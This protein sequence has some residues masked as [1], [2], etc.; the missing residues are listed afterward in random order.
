MPDNDQLPVVWRTKLRSTRPD[1]PV[2]HSEQVAHCLRSGLIGIG[3]GLDDLPDRTPTDVVLDAIEQKAEEGWGGRA[4]RIVR[5]FAI[6]AEIGDF[7]WTRDT[8][9]RYLL[10][11]LTGPHRY[12]MT[13]AASAVDVH[14]VRDADWARTP[15]NDL[16]VPGGVIRCFI[17]VGESF[18]RIHDLGA[19]RLTFYLWEKLHGRP[20][21]KLGVTPEEILTSYLDPY[22]VEDL[23]YVWLQ[24]AR[25]YLALP[26]AR[27]RDMPAYEYTMIHRENGRRAIAQVKTGS[28]PV[29]LSAL[30]AAVVDRETDTYA[31]ATSG[32]YHGDSSLV[33]EV[34]ATA[35]LLSFV[36]EHE[37][38]L[39]PRVRTWFQL[40][41]E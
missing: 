10:C 21:P 41:T 19:R 18:S 27:Q 14:Q 25:G 9:G 12:D 6:E 16:D 3:W 39:P 33:T 26:R 24:I 30:A 29:D 35:E 36:Q 17:G 7:V 11:R 5:R 8:R 37:P 23:I 32:S 34:I 1:P 15:L 22:D 2:D 20:L 31:Y 40:A 4:A 28:T 38:L 13:E